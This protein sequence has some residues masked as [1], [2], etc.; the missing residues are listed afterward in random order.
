M[1]KLILQSMTPCDSSENSL[2][3]VVLKTRAWDKEKERDSGRVIVAV[4]VCL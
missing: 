2:Q 1:Y 3:R 4:R